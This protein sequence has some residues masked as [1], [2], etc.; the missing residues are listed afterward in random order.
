[1]DNPR[2]TPRM[3]DIASHLPLLEGLE[4]GLPPEQPYMERIPSPYF[5]NKDLPAILKLM[6]EPLSSKPPIPPYNPLRFS[7]ARPNAPLTD[8]TAISPPLD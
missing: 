4:V 5:V 6:P 8:D 2:A 1:M 3:H 7:R